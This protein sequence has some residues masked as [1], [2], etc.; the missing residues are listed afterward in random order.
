VEEF[1]KLDRVP[2]ELNFVGEWSAEVF[3]QKKA[4]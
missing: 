3:M 2:V 1:T 4:S